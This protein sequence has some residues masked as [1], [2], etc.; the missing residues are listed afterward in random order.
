MRRRSHRSSFLSS[1]VLAKSFATL[2]V[3]GAAC[4]LVAL[5]VACGDNSGSATTAQGGAGGLGAANGGGG[6]GLP[7]FV[8]AIASSSSSTT[9]SS[10]SGTGGGPTCKAP[11]PMGGGTSL[12]RNFGDADV[13]S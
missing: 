12:A 2:A 1:F 9:S 6:D 7:D 4:G 8:T 3:M 5:G 11:N 10:G 13:Q